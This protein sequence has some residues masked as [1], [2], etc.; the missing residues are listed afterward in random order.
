LGA[1]IEQQ[2]TYNKLKYAGVDANSAWGRSIIEANHALHEQAKQ[3]A[4][5]IEIQDEWRSGLSD[6]ITD[7][8]TGAKSLKESFADFFDDFAAKITRMIAEKWIEKL[9]GETGSNGGGSAGNGWAG[10]IS[11][12]FGAFGGGKASGGSVAPGKFYEVG[13][14]DRPEMLMMRGRQ[15]MIPGNHGT[16]VPIRGNAGGGVSQN[17][18]FYYAAPPSP[19]TQQ[20][21]ADRV[22]FEVRRS[23]RN[24]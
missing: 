23:A 16:V 15:Y 24:R 5:S 18:N 21:T 14:G 12:L 13:E 11:S 8:V 22:A 1:T 3:M 2:D 17:L 19:Q 10:I 4:A 20:Q 9:F 6:A 7:F